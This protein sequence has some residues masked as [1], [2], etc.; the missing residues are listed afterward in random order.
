MAKRDCDF[1]ENQKLHDYLDGYLFRPAGAGRSIGPPPGDRPER[2]VAFPTLEAGQQQPMPSSRSTGEAGFFA[3]RGNLK[4]IN[5]KVMAMLVPVLAVILAW[6]VLNGLPPG[7]MDA[8]RDGKPESAGLDK[9]EMTLLPLPVVVDRPVPVQEPPAA[10][11]EQQDLSAIAE[12][13]EAELADYVVERADGTGP[14]EH[15]AAGRAG[16]VIKAILFSEDNPAAIV[17]D[18]LV[19]VGDV[20]SGA[21]IVQITK[22]SVVVEKDRSRKH[23]AVLEEVSVD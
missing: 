13:M 22:N 4:T 19:H 14:S 6:L 17:G 7:A 16:P 2:R 11:P 21:R 8:S 18:E 9:A 10:V 3:I 20:V 12:A 5:Q 1:D 23:L 15:T